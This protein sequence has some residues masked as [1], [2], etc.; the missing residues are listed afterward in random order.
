MAGWFTGR[1]GRRGREGEQRHK[2]GE[3]LSGKEKG[4]REEEEKEGVELESGG[5]LLLRPDVKLLST[6]LR[7]SST[8][9]S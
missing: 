5:G 1:E 8:Q 3:K 6:R 7:L 9:S 2:S 4:G